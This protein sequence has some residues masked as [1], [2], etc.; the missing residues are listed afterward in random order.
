MAA[1]LRCPLWHLADLREPA[2][3]GDKRVLRACLA[4][5]GLPGA[6]ARVKRAIQFGTRL[7][8]KANTEQFGGTRRANAASAG[9]VRLADVPLPAAL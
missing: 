1:T 7:A 9:S 8:A 2:G 4:R 3:V 6:A 5:L